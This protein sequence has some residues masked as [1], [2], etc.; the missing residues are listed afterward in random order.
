MFIWDSEA[1]N[2]VG[3]IEKD[4]AHIKIG[5]DKGNGA[6]VLADYEL[7]G[8]CTQSVLFYGP[9]A[10]QNAKKWDNWI[11]P[12]DEE[13]AEDRGNMLDDCVKALNLCFE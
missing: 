8:S 2:T 4:V 3:P 11:F 12:D 1:E 10:E 13:I 6:L 7:T 5:D 9:E